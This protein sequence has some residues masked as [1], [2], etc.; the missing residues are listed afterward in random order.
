M[1]KRD[2]VEFG[3]TGSS[4]SD[5]RNSNV[6]ADRKRI[7]PPQRGGPMLGRFGDSSGSVE[8]RSQQGD[9]LDNDK[10]RAGSVVHAKRPVAEVNAQTR[11][12]PMVE[13]AFIRKGGS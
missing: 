12:Q 3:M 4:M 11:Q 5:R 2:L 9:R 10:G 7:G 1:P 8:R 6:N 13:H